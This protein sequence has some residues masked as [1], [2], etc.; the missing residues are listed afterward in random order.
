[1]KL[2]DTRRQ[3][4]LVP[5]LLAMLAATGATA[6]AQGNA[7]QRRMSAAIKVVPRPVLVID[8]V[9]DGTEEQPKSVPDFEV[10]TVRPSARDHDPNAPTGVLNEGSHDRLR[11][12][13]MSLQAIVA[14]A[15]DV[16]DY[17][18]LGP[19]SIKTAHYDIVAKVP[20]EVTQLSD[21]QRGRLMRIELGSLLAQRFQLQVHTDTRPIDAYI[22]V[23]DK[24]G[25]TLHL[26]GLPAGDWVWTEHSAG[27]VQAKQMPMPQ[28]VDML[29][30]LLQCPV[31]DGTGVAQSFDIKLEWDPSSLSGNPYSLPNQAAASADD[32]RPSIFTALQE[33][34]GL[35]LSM[36]KVPTKVIVIDRVEGPT[37]N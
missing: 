21:E 36:R 23:P 3:C 20:Y 16:Q 24:R 9:V 10:A 30:H 29:A 6:W 4:V 14:E 31:V 32:P 1:M 37:P 11:L 19:R 2:R 25:V 17:Q 13:D 35:K 34:A 5:L 15:Y 12:L 33:Q 27:R 26:S 7:A 28:L 8:H 18:V 22:L